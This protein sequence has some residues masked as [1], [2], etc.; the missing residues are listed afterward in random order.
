LRRRS[1]DRSPGIPFRLIRSEGFRAVVEVEHLLVTA[2][3]ST[4][5]GR[6]EDHVSLATVRTWG[7]LVGAK[8]W[9]AERR[10]TRSRKPGGS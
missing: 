6:V 9:L 8:A 1:D 4:W 3:R 7:T 10:E 5:P 2:A